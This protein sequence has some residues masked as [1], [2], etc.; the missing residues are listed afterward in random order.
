MITN[1]AI[2]NNRGIKIIG[3]GVQINAGLYERLMAHQLTVPIEQSV[4]STS[5][6]TG[7]FLRAQTEQALRDLPFFERIGADRKN[8]SLLLD[9][10]T[11]MPL[12]GP[13][14]FQLTL[15]CEVR[16]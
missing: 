10:M 1:Q 14:A 6:I 11:K 12:P 2:F 7:Q 8:R 13:I 4:V 16:P 5:T 9:A 3:K 15:A